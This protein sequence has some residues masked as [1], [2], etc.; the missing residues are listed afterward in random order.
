MIFSNLYNDALIQPGREGANHLKIISGYA[1]AAM[2]FH[3]LEELNQKGINI[4]ISLLVGMCPSDG[5][6][7]S[8]HRGFQNIIS[9]AYSKCFSCSYVYSKPSV[10][11]KLYIWYKTGTF[12]K[13]FIGSPNYT[14]NAFSK[15]QREILSEIQDDHVS[16]YY[17]HIEKDSIY[18]NHADAEELVKIYNDKNYYLKHPHED[19]VAQIFPKTEGLED[20]RVSLLCRKTGDVPRIGGLN[21]GQRPGREPNQAYLQLPPE[22]Y[23]KDFFPKRP[24]HFTVVTDDSKSFICTRAQ[25]D[26]NNGHAVET[27]HN[28][29]L[30]GEYFRNRLG[31]Q[32]GA[33]ITKE[34]LLRYGRTDIT[35]YKFDDENFL[36]DF[37]ADG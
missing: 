16:E 17:N 34:D 9:S 26:L 8:N 31:L 33:K 11:A 1:S 22:V 25:K 2:A 4:S 20:I 14:Q 7:F 28:N 19:T 10:H 5:L 12:Y 24:Q 27:P 15:N 23:K 32:N 36:M 29:S 21:W 18:C 13:A 6:S 35:F 37:S 3:H 30:L